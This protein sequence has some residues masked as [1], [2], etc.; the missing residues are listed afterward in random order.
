MLHS[1]DSPSA[2]V[3]LHG[4]KVVLQPFTE[5]DITDSYLGWLNNAAVMRYSN[6]RFQRHDR[7]NAQSYLATF[8]NSPNL[9]FSICD[10][11][12]AQALGT[13]TAY[14]STHHGTVDCGIMVGEPRVWGRGIGQ[15][16]WDTWT[17]WCL[18]RPGMRKLTAGTLACNIGMLRLIERSGMALE[19]V[20]R[21]QE[22]VDGR[23]EN[24]QLYAKFNA[25]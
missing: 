13:L 22:L 12:T 1:Q 16:A 2:L 9:F 6:Q 25:G 7:Q 4:S 8:V 10:R 21:E 5:A 11:A 18:S 15:D 3:K 19:A 17:A 23:A 24:V 14:V 20:R